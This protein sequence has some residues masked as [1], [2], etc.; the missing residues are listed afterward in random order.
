[1]LLQ[2]VPSNPNPTYNLSIYEERTVLELCEMPD[3]SDATSDEVTVSASSS[4][5]LYHNN[6]NMHV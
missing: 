4:S 2:I 5:N 1:M 3:Q 6:I